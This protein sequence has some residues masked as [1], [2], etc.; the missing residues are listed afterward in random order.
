[1]IT[2]FLGD[3]VEYYTMDELKDKKSTFSSF[4]FA[5][6][7]VDVTFQRIVQVEICKKGTYTSRAS[8]S[9]TVIKWN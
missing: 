6:E 2:S 7:A 9:S 3:V 1:M 5:I 8:I 4:N